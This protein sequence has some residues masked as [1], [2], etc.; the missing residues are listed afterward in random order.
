MSDEEK[1]KKK[2]RLERY[3]S[4]L[5][6]S[7]SCV[8]FWHRILRQLS[9][10]LIHS[11]NLSTFNK[12]LLNTCYVLGTVRDAWD[13]SLSEP[14]RI[15]SLVAAHSQSGRI[16]LGLPKK[17]YPIRPCFPSLMNDFLEVNNSK[18]IQN[19]VFQTQYTIASNLTSCMFCLFKKRRAK[20][21]KL[22]ASDGSVVSSDHYSL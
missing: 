18:V 19:S 3:F 13:S 16:I 1:T 8:I 7:V 6:F 15:L 9:N 4:F 20:D 17:V 21:S 2:K 22:Q 14:K 11:L 10:Y 5:N 12:Y